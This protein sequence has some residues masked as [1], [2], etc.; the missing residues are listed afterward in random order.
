MPGENAAVV[1]EAYERFAATGQFVGELVTD[2]FAWDMSHF[3]GWPEQQLYEGP[4]EAWGFLAEW[5]G[6]WDDWELDVDSLREVGDKVLALVRQRGRSKTTGAPVDM[7]F[8]QI[9][10][11]RD[12][13][14]ARMEMYSDPA[15]ALQAVGLQE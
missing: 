1:R 6:A 10:T 12:G 2:D 14:Q 13:K 3:H 5:T 8:A 7:S 15:E 11:I 9:W 4:E